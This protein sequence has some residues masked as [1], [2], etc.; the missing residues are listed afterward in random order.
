ML[1]IVGRVLSSRVNIVFILWMVVNELV[2]LNR[3]DVT[4]HT[5]FSK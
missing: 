3:S 5:I 4:V 2:T 1:V